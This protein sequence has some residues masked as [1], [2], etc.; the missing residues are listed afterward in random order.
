MRTGTPPSS[1]WSLLPTLAGLLFAGLVLAG[2]SGS[3][4]RELPAEWRG[5]DLTEP[6]WASTT[7]Q[8][9]WGLAVEYVWSSGTAVEWDWFVNGSAVL[10]FKVVRMQDG[11][12]RTL[13]SLFGNE[14]AAGLTVPQAGAHQLLWRNEGSREVPFSYKVPEG[15]LLRSYSPTEGPDCAR[16]SVPALPLL[17]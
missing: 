2:C 3:D 8:P 5:R 6:G 11:Q 9:G 15:G 14:S 7:I 13:L 16:R 1:R 12:A 10:H 4:G 17:C